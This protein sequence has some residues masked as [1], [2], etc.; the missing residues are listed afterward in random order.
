[1][2]IDIENGF[3]IED[4]MDDKIKLKFYVS[5]VNI[6]KNFLN[7]AKNSQKN[8]YILHEDQLKAEG[9]ILSHGRYH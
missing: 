1:M 3:D 4:R 9:I 5:N 6:K 8:Y 2:F 7:D